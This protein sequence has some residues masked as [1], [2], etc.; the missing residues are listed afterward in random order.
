MTVHQH[1]AVM[2]VRN[3]TTAASSSPHYDGVAMYQR[4]PIPI[5]SC[6]IGPGVLAAPPPLANL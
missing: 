5:R 2:I 4:N 1:R 3:M 6:G